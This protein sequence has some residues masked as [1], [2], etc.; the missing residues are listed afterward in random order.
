MTSS[1]E[2]PLDGP[3]DGS[4]YVVILDGVFSDRDWARFGMDY[5]QSNGYQPI[6]VETY[7]I[8]FSSNKD[9]VTTGGNRSA[10]G[11]FAPENLGQLDAFLER[12]S[13][14]DLILLVMNFPRS[15]YLYQ[16]LRRLG[17]KFAKMDL[18]KFPWARKLTLRQPVG[19]IL[20]DLVQ[21]I[22]RALYRFKQ[23]ARAFPAGRLRPEWLGGAPAPD[24]LITAGKA[25]DTWFPMYP[26][27]PKTEVILSVSN[28]IWL[29]KQLQRD[30][31]K[32]PPTAPA[33]KP[34]AVFVHSPF[35]EHTDYIM[36]GWDIMATPERYYP[37]L[38]RLFDKV[39][40]DLGLEVI[41]AGHPRCD[42]AERDPRFGGR[43][44]LTGQTPSLVR[45]AGLV[46]L[47]QSTAV[48]FACY[49]RRPILFI[50]TDELEAW[51]HVK[52]DQDNLTSWFHRRSLNIDRSLGSGKMELPAVD[53]ARYDAFQEQFLG[54]LTFDEE[55]NL[56]PLRRAFERHL[57]SLASPSD[58]MNSVTPKKTAELA[59]E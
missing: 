6:A 13:Q 43:R 41:I 25:R 30:A 3:P 24:W 14:R 31:G 2:L 26:L 33:G 32:S 27:S 35:I 8:F 42:Y 7:K 37:A 39:E 9:A 16:R 23:A 18:S 53:N 51:H 49:F 12:L 45:D 59:H 58:R 5:F 15:P 48:S 10:A 11:V 47:H 17:L 46:I 57:A 36:E 20:Q 52:V 19:R 50:T 40:K 38:R 54:P 56:A 21:G 22:H 55:H 44:T 29:A 34:Y 4:R 1:V 28:D